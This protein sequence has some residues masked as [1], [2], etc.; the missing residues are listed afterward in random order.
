MHADV[1]DLM[2]GDK[3]ACE[4]CNIIKESKFFPY[5]SRPLCLWCYEKIHNKTLHAVREKLG[6]SKFETSRKSKKNALIPSQKSSQSIAG[7]PLCPSCKSSRVEKKGR[8]YGKQRYV[9]KNCKKNWTGNV[10]SDSFISA[11]PER[12]DAE[13]KREVSLSRIKA[14]LRDKQS[15]LEPIKFYYRN[16]TTPRESDNYT[17]DSNYVYF[18][19]GGGRKIT[20]RIDRIRKV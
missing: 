19:V 1:T 14:Y 20:F 10:T 6:L 16:D 15:K 2:D 7:K 4:K 8:R 18:R 3:R 5:K 9:C 17:V 13:V 12:T 11:Q